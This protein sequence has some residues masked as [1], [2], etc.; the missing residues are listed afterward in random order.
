MKRI[1][2][3]VINLAKDKDRKEYMEELLSLC[4]YLDVEFI[5][6]VYGK[7]LVTSEIPMVFDSEKS[8]KRYGRYCDLG[9]IGCTLSHRKI[10]K[11][12]V[13]QRIDYALI[14]EDDI[15][16][17][18]DLENTLLSLDEYMQQKQ[19]KIVLLSGGYTYCSKKRYD[20]IK[21]AKVY[22]ANYTHSYLISNSAAQVLLE[23]EV[24]GIF[25]DDWIYISKKKILVEAV[26]P[27]VIDQNRDG[28]FVSNV[29]EET[30]K[31]Y[32]K[33]LSIVRLITYIQNRIIGKMLY[34]IGRRE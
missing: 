16:I 33:N 11:K 14:L 6:A 12:I 15:S 28:R 7:E 21:L 27:H 23:D 29:W 34:Q 8:Y 32:K 9:E 13:E 20:G 4:S 31:I 25:A 10:Y 24:P 22:D 17:K 30:H 5:E 19:T 1:K 2:T 18:G 3:Y 26:Y